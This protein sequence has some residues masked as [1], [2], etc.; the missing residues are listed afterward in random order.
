MVR[1]DHAIIETP[2]KVL[3]LTNVSSFPFLTP[4]PG[5]ENR[6]GLFQPL[7]VVRQRSLGHVSRG[8]E[9]TVPDPWWPW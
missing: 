2:T 8:T 4:E 7:K 6:T 5:Q 9:H 3:C 1:V